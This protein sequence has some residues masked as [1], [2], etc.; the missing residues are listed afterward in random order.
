MGFEGQYLRPL[1]ARGVW[2]RPLGFPS[3]GTLVNVKM[4]GKWMLFI[5]LNTVLSCIII[6]DHLWSCMI[7]YDHVW[8]CMIM[9]DH[10]W[11]SMIIY[12][13]LWSCITMYNH[14]WSCMIMYDH[15]L[16]C[17]I[18][19]YLFQLLSIL[20]QN[21]TPICTKHHP[22]LV[23]SGNMFGLVTSETWHLNVP[24]SVRVTTIVIRCYKL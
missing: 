21:E 2:S 7:M 15:V 9:Y 8:S 16:S 12:D 18:W 11:S 14:L 19:L 13:H 17:I 4:I 6:Y 20:C 10:V 24:W 5:S 3:P 1:E 23:Y 22:I